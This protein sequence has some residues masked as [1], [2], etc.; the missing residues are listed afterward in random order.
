MSAPIRSARLED[1]HAL[2]EFVR[3]LGEFSGVT[4]EAPEV[5]LRRVREHLGV[6]V[7]SDR[8]SLLVAEKDGNLVGYC[9]VHWLPMMSQLEGFISEL[10]V[11][12]SHRGEGVGTELLEAVKAEA[13]T[14]GCGRLHLE[15]FRTKDS[16]VRSYYA[17]QGWHERTA[18]ASFTMDLREP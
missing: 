3:D 4:R 15:N 8:H 2:A 1:A 16:Y 17:K 11:A 5:T 9:S 18:A 6:I 10:F 12:A 13:R 7:S 14:R